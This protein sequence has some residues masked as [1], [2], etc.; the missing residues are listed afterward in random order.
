MAPVGFSKTGKK[1]FRF[2]DVHCHVLYGVDDGS[3]SPEMSLSMLKQAAAEGV[4]AMILTPHFFAGRSAVTKESLREKVAG[5]T[6]LCR[7]EGIAIEL[8]PG[9]ELYYTEDADEMLKNGD[10]PTL[11]GTNRLLVEFSTD[12]LAVQILNAVK[13]ISLLGYVPVVAHVERYGS[14]IFAPEKVEALRAQ[15]AEIQ[16]NVSTLAGSFGS[17]AKAAAETLLKKQLVDYLGTDAHDDRVRKVE[18]QK[19]IGRL[20]KKFDREY[21]EEITYLNARTLIDA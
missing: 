15:G 17:R 11:N 19:T 14:V 16:V 3:R 13:K 21:V 1:A 12:I 18:V 2:A 7:E 6:A 8:C 9:A 20:M 5:L 10:V 4:E